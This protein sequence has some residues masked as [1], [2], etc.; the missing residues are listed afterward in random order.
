MLRVAT[1]LTLCE[2]LLVKER[3]VRHRG[4]GTEI[5]AVK[6]EALVRM[7]LAVRGHPGARR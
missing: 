5:R 2:G 7:L 3:G 1:H 6:L 4:S